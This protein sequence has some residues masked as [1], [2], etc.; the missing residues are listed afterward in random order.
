MRSLPVV[1][2]V[3]L[4]LAGPLAPGVGHAHDPNTATHFGLSPAARGASGSLARVGPMRSMSGSFHA[5]FGDAPSGSGAAAVAGYVLIDDQGHTTELIVDEQA[6]RAIGGPRVVNHRRVVVTGQTVLAP[7]TVAAP[8][9]AVQAV[10]VDGPQPTAADVALSAAVTGSQPWITILCRFGDMPAVTP[11]SV[12]WFNTLMLGTVPPGLDHYW[13]ELSF[14]NVNLIGGAVVGWYTLPQ[15]RSYYVYGS[16]LQL[17]FQRASQDCTGVADADV[18]F[19]NFVGI[20]LMFN[21]DL[22]GFA[23]GGSWTLTRDGVT[24]TYRMTWV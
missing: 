7:A 1:V 13:R 12:S 2:I 16:P 21:D 6:L 19:P 15:P 9:F 3:A 20:N 17:D 24:R 8:L 18:Y 5:I 4:L 11:Q 22:D 10:Q 14:N 23:W